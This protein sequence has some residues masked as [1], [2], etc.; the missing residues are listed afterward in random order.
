MLIIKKYTSNQNFNDFV[1]NLTTILGTH[2]LG[3]ATTSL[4]DGNLGPFIF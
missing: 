1:A 2:F 3:I 4:G